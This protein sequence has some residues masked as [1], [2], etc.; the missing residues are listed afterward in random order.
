[1]N[2]EN[3]MNT[4]KLEFANMGIGRT[5]ALFVCALVLLNCLLISDAYP[6]S[7]TAQYKEYEVKAAFMYNF[8][9]FVDWPEGKMA[10][11]SNQIIIGIIGQDPFGSAVDIL[12]DKKVE[13]RNVV[14]KHFDGLQQL[15]DAAEKEKT[16]LSDKIKAL[17]K[18]QIVYIDNDGKIVMKP[19]NEFDELKDI[20]DGAAREKKIEELKKRGYQ[21]AD[22]SK[23]GDI[24]RIIE[25]IA[26]GQIETLKKCHLLFICPSEKK[27]INEIIGL[28]NNQ[29]VLTVADTQEFLDIGGIVNFIIEDN[30][31]RFDINLTA[32]EKAGLKIRSQL[33]RLAKKVIKNGVEVTGLADTAKK[34]AK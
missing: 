28:V 34:E 18:S 6:E 22:P 9:K 24:K 17:S 7:K 21:L 27:N 15:K 20:T 3:N 32:S 8:L 25:T 31:V 10:G 12:K 23:T 11:N 5:A 1:M 33:L 13:D 2:Q 14:I 16:D 4:I 30:K 29:G 19:A 26:N